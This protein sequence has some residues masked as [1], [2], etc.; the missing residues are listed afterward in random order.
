MGEYLSYDVS[1]NLGPTWSNIALVTFVTTKEVLGG[2]EVLHMK[3]NGKTYPMYDHLFKIRDSYESWVNPRTWEPIKFLQYTVHNKNTILLSQLF[4]PAQLFFLYSYKLNNEPVTKG[5]IP[6]E[7]CMYDMVSASYFPRTLDLENMR[8]GTAIPV[9]LVFNNQPTSLQMI[10]AGKGTIEARNG[11]KYLCNKF[12]IRINSTVY[13]FKE[14]S[15]VVVWL[16]AD[17]NKVPVFVEAELII[18]SVKIYLKEAKGLRNTMTA[19][20]LK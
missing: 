10:A 4:Y 13:F 14:G 11:K 3:L 9:S 17:K 16:T 5:Q 20:I 19:S 8:P 18:G 12:T 7:K 6:V 2:R 1:Y 15:D